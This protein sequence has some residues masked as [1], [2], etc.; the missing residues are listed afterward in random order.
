[1]KSFPRIGY[2]LNL[3]FKPYRPRLLRALHEDDYDRR[4]QFCEIMS[5][6]IAAE[7]LFCW[8][9][10]W[11]DEATF[12]LNGRVSRHN[13]IYWSDGNPHQVIGQEL[14]APGVALG[15]VISYDHFFFEDTVT[16][17]SYLNKLGRAVT[18]KLENN[19]LFEARYW[20]NLAAAWRTT[21]LCKCW[22]RV[23][24]YDFVEFCRRGRW[25]WPP[26][27]CDITSCDFSMWNIMTD[28]FSKNLLMLTINWKCF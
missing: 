26:R 11:T 7:P 25:N 1:M 12:K 23:H 22:T 15:T 20:V 3:K 9:I 6:W 18:P 2:S 21:T 14:D 13:S 24:G 16:G 19:P 8:K 17:D 27:S 10:L 4:V 5:L 28:V